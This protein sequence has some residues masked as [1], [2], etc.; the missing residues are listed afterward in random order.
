MLDERD[1]R[2]ISGLLDTRFDAFEHKLDKKLDQKLE[3]LEKKITYSIGEMLEQ[4]IFPQFDGI[5]RELRR[6]NTVIGLQQ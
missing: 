3:Q 2:V 4:N 6:I 1:V 5:H